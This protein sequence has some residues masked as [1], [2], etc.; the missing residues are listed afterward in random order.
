MNTSIGILNEALKSRGVGP[1]EVRRFGPGQIEWKE[2]TVF[3]SLFLLPL[4]TTDPKCPSSLV[5]LG[6]RLF[7]EFRVG[8]GAAGHVAHGSDRS[9]ITLYIGPRPTRPCS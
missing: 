6:L 2:N 9:P 8:P 3:F 1:S 4:Q 7:C 5:P